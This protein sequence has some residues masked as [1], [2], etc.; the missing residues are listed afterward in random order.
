MNKFTLPTIHLNGTS[1]ESLYE[2][3]ANALGAM[4]DALRALDKVSPN[5]RDYYPQG[6][7]AINEA[8]RE[9]DE[10]VRRIRSV[11]REL[12]SLAEHVADA[13]DGAR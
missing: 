13:Q 1:A 12:E 6:P 7:H 10:R 4:R 5:A 9:H 11:M 3:L 8:L 2:D